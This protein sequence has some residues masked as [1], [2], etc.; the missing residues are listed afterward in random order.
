MKPALRP[1]AASLLA[2]A[3]ELLQRVPA[4][5][6]AA[7]DRARLRSL[8]DDAGVQV[9]TSDA[10]TDSSRP[11]L[12]PVH[13]T[14][15]ERL[16]LE[17]AMRSP[18]VGPTFSHEVHDFMLV[19]ARGYHHA[20]VPSLQHVVLPRVF[21]SGVIAFTEDEVAGLRT[22]AVAAGIGSLDLF[23]KGCA[24][25]LLSSLQAQWPDDEDLQVHTP[26]KPVPVVHFPPN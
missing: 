17:R 3:L 14:A 22:L 1:S 23:I 15:P 21:V 2:R 6:L 5:H 7:D 9:E 26:P 25:A 20:P 8:L 19:A 4:Q 24:F 13:L 10:R 11:R 18:Q 12:F 16:V